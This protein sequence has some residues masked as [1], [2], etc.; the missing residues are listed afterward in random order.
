[1]RHF[2]KNTNTL[3][4]AVIYC[5]FTQPIEKA[6]D[7]F[8]KV[9]WYNRDG[10]ESTWFFSRGKLCIWHSAFQWCLIDADKIKQELDSDCRYKYELLKEHDLF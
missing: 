8:N 7:N 3:P 4:N 6:N 9:A 1:M 5:L 10:K 2:K